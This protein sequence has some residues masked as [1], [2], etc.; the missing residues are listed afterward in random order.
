MQLP[1]KKNQTKPHS[2]FLR[3]KITKSAFQ[4]EGILHPVSL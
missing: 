2:G 4:L 1:L 3:W